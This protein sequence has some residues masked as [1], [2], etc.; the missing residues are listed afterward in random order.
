MHLLDINA[1]VFPNKPEMHPTTNPRTHY[2]AHSF[3][4][5]PSGTTE[6]ADLVFMD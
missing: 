6:R 5:S 4:T 1:L 3:T 2:I